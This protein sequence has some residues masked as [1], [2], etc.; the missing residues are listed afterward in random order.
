MKYQL[1]SVLGLLFFL[2]GCAATTATD[3]SRTQFI[4]STQA[5]PACGRT[6]AQ[7]V[8][9]NMAAVEV[10]RR[11]FD[12][13]FIVDARTQNNVSVVRTGP[14]YANTTFTGLNTGFGTAN[15][16]FGGQQTIVAG[17]ND[18]ELLIVMVEPGS[19]GYD[20]ALDARQIL[21]PEWEELVENGIKTCT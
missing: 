15:T 13:Y 19:R 16:T 12:R 21:G 7:R 5:A 18:A 4:L 14:T 6:G 11:G 9:T 20:D 17:S 2:G 1:P 3:L 8:A 10:L